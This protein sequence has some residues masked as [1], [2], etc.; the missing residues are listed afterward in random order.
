M[1]HYGRITQEGR[2]DATLAFVDDVGEPKQMAW[3]G[4][5]VG[6]FE[7]YLAA[8]DEQEGGAADVYRNNDTND[9]LLSARGGPHAPTASARWRLWRREYGGLMLLPQ[10][11]LMQ[12]GFACFVPLHSPF[13]SSV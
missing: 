10:L 11:R 9:D 4:G 5:E 3:D 12:L 6:G 1:A 8:E 13:A 2:L 7:C